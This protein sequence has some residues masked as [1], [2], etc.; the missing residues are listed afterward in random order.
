MLSI[1]YGMNMLNWTEGELQKLEVIRNKVGR[2]ALGANGYAGV[3]AVRGGYG[4]EYFQ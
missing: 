1:M 2:V 3:E 4:L